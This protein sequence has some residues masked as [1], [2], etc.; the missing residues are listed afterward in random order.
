MK[1][2]DFYEND[3][4]YMVVTEVVSGGEL[5]DRIVDKEFYNEEE[6]RKIVLSLCDALAYVHN[7]GVTHRDLKPGTICIHTYDTD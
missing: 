6:A 2:F 3:L 1:F 4:E 7:K 5:F